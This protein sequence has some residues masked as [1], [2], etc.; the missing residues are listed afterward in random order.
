MTTLI[1]I[2]LQFLH[3]IID[4]MNGIKVSTPNLPK[5]KNLKNSAASKKVAPQIAQSKETNIPT[6]KIS[7]EQPEDT[8]TAKENIT[9]ET[10]SSDD[11]AKNNAVPTYGK[12]NLTK[13]NKKSD[14][15]LKAPPAPA[16]KANNTFN[17]SKRLA[18]VSSSIDEGQQNIADLSN[19]MQTSI[20]GGD[21]G[22]LSPA[23]IRQQLMQERA[24]LGLRRISFTENIQEI[25]EE[26][27]ARAALQSLSAS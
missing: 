23:Q 19:A 18:E 1:L 11:T 16:E 7:T 17:P 21:A 12:L 22:G 5:V 10:N 20:L 26:K 27:K 6:T 8:F 24:A 14:Q 4:N 2:Y 13:T 15:P 9:A 25:E 3:V